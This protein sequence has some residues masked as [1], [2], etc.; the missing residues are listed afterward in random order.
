MN[1]KDIIAMMI[2]YF[3][4]LNKYPIILSTLFFEYKSPMP[5]IANLFIE[6]T[7]SLTNSINRKLIEKIV[8]LAKSIYFAINILSVE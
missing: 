5:G 3:A 7:L 1:P 2:I 4:C 8:T 6:Y